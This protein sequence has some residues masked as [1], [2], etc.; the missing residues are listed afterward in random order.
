M[1]LFEFIDPIPCYYH[2]STIPNLKILKRQPSKLTDEGVVF[3]ATMPEIAI[4]MSGHWTDDDFSFGHDTSRKHPDLVFPPYIM[5][6]LRQN[7]FRKFFQQKMYIYEV[8]AKY[9][10]KHENLQD[11][12]VVSYTDVPIHTMI[13]VDGVDDPLAYIKNS[14]I[15]RLIAYGN[16][17]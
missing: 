11:F 6:E 17:E 13:K 3:A 2:G 1:R 4:A 14:P 15:F 8:P 9:F 10:Q 7:A 12:E 5:R 16:K